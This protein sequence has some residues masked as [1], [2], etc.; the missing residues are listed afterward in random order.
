MSTRTTK[1]ANP[2]PDPEPSSNQVVHRL[3]R[4][5]T[6][7]ILA[8]RSLRAQQA[9]VAAF[10]ERR[11]WKCYI[12]VCAGVPPARTMVDAPIARHPTNRLKM[13][14]L[15]PSAHPRLRASAPPPLR[16]SAPPPLHPSAPPPLRPSAPPPLHASAL[17]QA[18]AKEGEGRESTS[19]VHTLGH[20]GRRAVV[21]VL[22]RTGRTHQVRVHMQHLRHPLLGDPVYGDANWNRLEAKRATRPMLHA[23]QLRL[24]HPMPEHSDEV[25]CLTAPPPDDLTALVADVVGCEAT[26]A[27]VGEWL[28]TKVGSE[29]AYSL[30]SF[31]Y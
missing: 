6:G 29:L 11:V 17:L 5:T 2:N 7:V 13:V 23:H 16:P 14:R 21:A 3:D 8:A 15:H 9:M 26:P 20:D 24:K 30:E 31:K 10:A 25:L 27:A 12:A 28:E 22:I 19:F 4:Y 18:V 1:N